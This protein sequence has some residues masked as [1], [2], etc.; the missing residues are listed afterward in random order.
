MA[1][2]DVLLSGHHGEVERWRREQALER[3]R[4]AAGRTCSAATRVLIYS[5]T[6]PPEPRPRACVRAAGQAP[7]SEREIPDM[8]VLDEIVADQIRTDL[9]RARIG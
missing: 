5:A 6:D 7:T 2:P 1:V 8:T 4:R 3:T 9:P